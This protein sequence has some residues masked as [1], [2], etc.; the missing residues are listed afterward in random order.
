MTTKTVRDIE[1]LLDE[2]DSPIRLLRPQFWKMNFRDMCSGLN[3]QFIDG[4]SADQVCLQYE[5]YE[6]CND[7][8]QERC[9]TVLFHVYPG[10]WVGNK[11]AAESMELLQT[12]GITHLLNCAGGHATGT[13]QC[14]MLQIRCNFPRTHSAYYLEHIERNKQFS[15]R[16]KCSR[17]V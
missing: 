17:F 11:G 14:A 7:I 3:Q 12:Q 9:L 4:V 10:V 5:M 2:T 16:R 6:S 1:K 15:T 8:C 13:E